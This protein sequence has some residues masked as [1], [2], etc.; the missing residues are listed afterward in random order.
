MKGTGATTTSPWRKS[1]VACRRSGC[2]TPRPCRWSAAL[3][4]IALP[5]AATAHHSTRAIFDRSQP[6]EVEGTISSVFWRNPH[7][8]LTLLVENEAGETEEWE[9]EGGTF[10]DLQRSGFDTQTVAIGDR[11]RIVGA[12]SRRG[13]N[14]LYL[15]RLLSP[16]G[17]ELMSSGV[18]TTDVSGSPGPENLSA[19]TGIFRVWVFGGTLHGLRE[20]LSVT[21]VAEAARAAWDPFTD[22]PSHRCQA[23]GMPNAVLNPYPLEFVDQGEQ[24]VQRI[25][26]WDAVRTIHMSADPSADPAGQAEASPLGYSVGRWEGNTLV[27]ETANIDYPLLDDSGTPMSPAVRVVERYALSEDDT[28]LDLE[29]TAT[30]PPNLAAPAVWTAGWDW[31]PGV[32]VRPFECTVR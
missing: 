3:I 10:N 8:G 26:E 17:E 5:L 6:T 11:V 30:D 23:P 7:I 22:D 32:Q 9:I 16:V 4:L 2:H 20:P 27:V 18:R 14:E 12:S 21:P 25:E 19:P 29:L 31:G 24:I 1:R 28:R 15:D 13:L